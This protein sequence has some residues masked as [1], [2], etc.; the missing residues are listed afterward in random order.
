VVTVQ[1]QGDA[2]AVPAPADVAD[3]VERAPAQDFQA[4]TEDVRAQAEVEA[5]A[6]A[7][8]ASARADVDVP[9]PRGTSSATPQR[10]YAPDPLPAAPAPPPPPPPP[11]PPAPPPPPVAAQESAALGEAPVTARLQPGA[12]DTLTT[13]PAPP[14]ARM[15]PAQATPARTA[16]SEGAAVQLLREHFPAQFGSTQFHRVWLVRDADGRVLLS[17]EL[18][19]G[20]DYEDMR[21]QLRGLQGSAPGPWQVRQIRN[22]A[23]QLIELA[24]AEVEPGAPRR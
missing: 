7:S 11:S 16:E 13:V 10:G 8:G 12:P 24:I 15:S 3:A 2:P 9:A 19:V 6:D 17:G 20:Q 22:G 18:E 4:G 21:G 14:T 5:E 23:G 1:A